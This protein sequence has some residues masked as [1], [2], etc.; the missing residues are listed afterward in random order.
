MRLFA[1][2]LSFFLITLSHARNE[3]A[4]GAN[5]FPMVSSGES[6]D[7]RAI[8][9]GEYAR[10]IGI[11]SG[12]LRPLHDK[13]E[14]LDPEM[15][16]KIH[17]T[18]RTIESRGFEFY[19]EPLRES[20]RERL[21]QVRDNLAEI[22]AAF[23]AS[24]SL[25]EGTPLERNLVV[26]QNRDLVYDPTKD[27]F[28]EYC[29]N[30]PL[31]NKPEYE[32]FYGSA[33]SQDP[34]RQ[35]TRI[36]EF[37]VGLTLGEISGVMLSLEENAFESQKRKMKNKLLNKTIEKVVAQTSAYSGIFDGVEA[38]F[39][40]LYQCASSTGVQNMG[41]DSLATTIREAS[42]EAASNANLAREQFSAAG[43]DR[44][45]AL[46]RDQVR[47]ALIAGNL[48]DVQKRIDSFRE[49]TD[50][51]VY[52]EELRDVE[53][54][55]RGYP[56][57]NADNQIYN[58]HSACLRHLG[59]P[60]HDIPDP[61]PQELIDCIE[62][63]RQ[64]NRFH[65][66]G[67]CARDLETKAREEF[68]KVLPIMMAKVDSNPLLFNR[69]D[70]ANLV[71]MST[72]ESEFKPS[73]LTNMILNLPGASE[74]SKQL[75]MIVENDPESSIENIDKFFEE[76]AD[77]LKGVMDH[78]VKED[79]AV[80]DLMKAEIGRYQ[81][82]LVDAAKGVCENDGEYLH[83]FPHLMEE[84]MA[85]ELA[86]A[87]E[88]GTSKDTLFE[89][90][91][92][93]CWMLGENPPD[94]EAGLSTGMAVL[95]A[96]GAIA[97][98]VF[99]PL[100]GFALATGLAGYDGIQQ[101]I[102]AKEKFDTT[103]AAHAGGWT[104]AQD[105]LLAAGRLTDSRL[106]LGG[107]VAAAAFE[108][109]SLVKH[110]LRGGNE[111]VSALARADGVVETPGASRIRFTDEEIRANQ[112]LGDEARIARAAEAGLD[113]STE[114]RRNA[115]LTSH[116]HYGPIGNSDPS[117]FAFGSNGRREWLR[118]K[119]YTDQ[120]IET[121]L[122]RYTSEELL[123][124]AR[125]L[126]EA[127]FGRSEISTCLAAG[128]CGNAPQGLVSR[129]TYDELFEGSVFA[130]SEV[131]K[132][133][134]L[135]DVPIKQLNVMM[136]KE[137]PIPLAMLS[138]RADQSFRMAF[139]G[140]PGSLAER[141]R[142]FSEAGIEAANRALSKI[143]NSFSEFKDSADVLAEI[144]KRRLASPG[145]FL[146]PN[147]IEVIQRELH[148]A[149]HPELYEGVD[150]MVDTAIRFTGFDRRFGAGT[151]DP[152]RIE[153]MRLATSS[154]VYDGT[155]ALVLEKIEKIVARAATSPEGQARMRLADVMGS[156][157]S[158]RIM[159][160]V[161]TD[162]D[163]NRIF[164]SFEEGTEEVINRLDRELTELLN[165]EKSLAERAV[166]ELAEE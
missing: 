89:L 2:F 21:N 101:N 51:Q 162:P 151:G 126:Q 143:D 24:K 136:D 125:I 121:Y 166:A 48:F 158:L 53:I 16:Q 39:A 64:I 46:L 153:M 114:G 34:E 80:R 15:K 100:A 23:P 137:P 155:P 148:H 41:D 67:L 38:D 99:N 144:E 123:A 37:N 58:I 90:Q 60:G 130:E 83:Q 116:N 32:Q 96:A 77:A 33:D 10:L 5:G 135:I 6:R 165:Q 102:E 117:Q 105:V 140:S 118:S 159:R 49:G 122:N 3:F 82:E 129:N 141:S 26:D 19:R 152:Q 59:H 7:S 112:L 164:S 133:S 150:E 63:Y 139:K 98:G 147:E 52:C 17:D 113:L 66:G 28:P 163:N 61:V 86:L 103:L 29:K 161:L 149:A 91:S 1:F 42:M 81:D 87:A 131:R 47:Q 31:L 106:N 97:V 78:A 50:A 84:L 20:S 68:P 54:R 85:E 142:A 115:V 145:E 157:D 79:S 8:S 93:Y 22:F 109:G 146:S 111:V 9:H 154:G 94:A 11:A 13:T 30:Y 128:L 27:Y 45:E 107:E 25:F 35:C 127:G 72:S 120:E 70:V 65:N 134:N 62:D 40:P 56:L 74:L 110:A 138:M 156:I 76:N 132:L 88:N 55:Q 95:G 18:F 69:D 57:L 36:G 108:A 124:K 75:Q 160:E 92:T 71:P 43:L 104:D 12:Y 4:L 44:T 14:N 73:A 119:G